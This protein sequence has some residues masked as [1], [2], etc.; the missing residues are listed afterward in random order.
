MP[1]KLASVLSSDSSK[2]LDNPSSAG[3]YNPAI[4]LPSPQ[5]SRG[6]VRVLLRNPVLVFSHDSNPTCDRWLYA[7][8]QSEAQTRMAKGY[9]RFV[10]PNRVQLKPPPDWIPP[11]QHTGLFGEVWR[12]RASANYLVWQMVPIKGTE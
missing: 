2:Q 4:G 10:T 5:T 8:S 1:E 6:V 9:V 11:T 12:I 3:L 7:I